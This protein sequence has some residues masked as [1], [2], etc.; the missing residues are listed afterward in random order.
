[1]RYLILLSCCLFTLHLSA[2]PIDHFRFSDDEKSY[3]LTEWMALN[4]T[5]GLSYYL[6]YGDG[7][8][9]SWQSGLRKADENTAL[10]AEAI[11]PVGSMSKAPVAML[12]LMLVAEGKIELDGA[13]NDYLKQWQIEGRRANEVSV[14]DLLLAKKRWGSDYKPAGYA[15]DQALPSLLELLNGDAPSL[16]NGIRLKGNR[17][18]NTDTEYGNWLILQQ[19]IEEQLDGSLPELAQQYLFEPLGM[20]HSFYAAELSPEQAALVP[21][22]HEEDGS[23]MAS[24]YLRYPELAAGGLWT[25][26]ADYAKLVRH[27]QAAAAG[28]DN[29]ILSVDLAQQGLERQHGFRSL[30]FH[31]NDYGDPYWGGNCRGFYASFSCSLRYGWVNVA[32]SNR[33]LNWRVVNFMMG[34]AHEWVLD[35]IV[36]PAL[37]GQ[38]SNDR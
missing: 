1:M 28:E 12:T 32:C 20:E 31:I 7:Q 30:I 36:E 34:Q 10:T 33:Q 38:E 25:T 37:D 6:S 5:P 17:G 13:V 14:R 3:S 8:E 11:F 18:P 35:Q 19:L 15:A 21:Y 16:P 22:G 26:P 29:R 23:L 2:Q 27:V 4:Q 24:Q 9:I